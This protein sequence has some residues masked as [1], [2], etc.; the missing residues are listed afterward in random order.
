MPITLS[1]TDLFTETALKDELGVQGT[2]PISDELI[3]RAIH[4]ASDAVVGY[5]GRAITFKTAVVESLP[6]R[7][8]P[9]LY[10]SRTPVT[11]VNSVKINDET[12]TTDDFEIESLDRGLLYRAALWPLVATGRGSISRGSTSG[13][14]ESNVD[15]DYDGG[16]VTKPGEVQQLVRNLPFDIEQAALDIAVTHLDGRG[17]DKDVTTE[18]AEGGQRSYS[19]EIGLP[20]NV[21]R[22]LDQFRRVRFA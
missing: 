5:L 11:A 15:V 7:N 10:L 20:V 9:W 21:R 4:A 8:T 19:Q 3:E 1:A 17:R 2:E 22:L 6:G 18:S 13:Y 14:E 16:W 12:L